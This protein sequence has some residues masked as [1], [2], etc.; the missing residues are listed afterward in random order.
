MPLGSATHESHKGI[1]RRLRK[2]IHP[3]YTYESTSFIKWNSGGFILHQLQHLIQ[4]SCTIGHNKIAWSTDS[5]AAPKKTQA[6]RL[7]RH[8]EQ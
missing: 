8:R 4:M 2:E 6:G 5:M 7:P 3:E 1:L